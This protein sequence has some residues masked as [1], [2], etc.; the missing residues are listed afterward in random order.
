MTGLLGKTRQEWI[1]LFSE[2]ALPQQ[3]VKPFMIA[4]Y[5]EISETPF[6]NDS[7][8]KSAY[9]LSSE[10]PIYQPELSR[11]EQSEDDGSVKFLFC[12]KDGKEIETVLIPEIGRLTLCISSQVGCQQKC[13]FCFTGK[14]GLLRNLTTEEI[15]TQVYSVNKWL[16]AN[17]MWME[18]RHCS[19]AKRVTN[20]V[21]MGM[22]EPLDNMDA[23][24]PAIDILKDPWGLAIAPRKIT[25]STAGHLDGLKKLVVS[26][27]G[28][29]IALSL[30]AADESLR[31]RLMP[32]NRKFSLKDVLQVMFSY[33]KENNREIFIQYTL[34]S[35][36]N[37][38]KED[39]ARLINLLH[40]KP[41]KVNLIPFNEVSFS[42]L[43]RPDNSVV[44]EFQQWLLK[45]RIRTTV[46]FSKGRDIKA[47]CGQLVREHNKTPA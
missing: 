12:M 41:V 19:S 21:F 11:L 13:V 37:D 5:R 22:G 34:F 6:E 35:G 47:A 14:M 24:L 25:V 40:D 15:V 38:R 39:A 7:M 16:K 20:V 33:G 1:Q 23:L 8:P 27:P 26:K 17:P 4:A 43:K 9:G 36:V 18:E 42:K 3:H 46:R 28:T 2:K 31:N 30:H 45:G 10:F 29:S 44:R 32:I